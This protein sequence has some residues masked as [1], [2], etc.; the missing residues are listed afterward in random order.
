[1]SVAFSPDGK[2]IAAGMGNWDR[3][4]R[5]EV[6][7][8]ATRKSL[9]SRQEPRGVYSVAFSPDSKRVAWSGWISQ[10]CIDHVAPH[11]SVLRVPLP[12][13]NFYV[14]YSGDRKWLALAG[15]NQSLRLLDPQ[16]GKQAALLKGDSLAYFCVAFSSNSKLLAAGGGR[17]VGWGAGSG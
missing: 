9:W 16:T 2:R 3:P 15:E 11:R 10:L 5:V 6:W 7:D 8:F 14:A 4:G 13:H 17:H 1:I 12:E